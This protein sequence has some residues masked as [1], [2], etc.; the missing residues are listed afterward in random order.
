VAEG[1]HAACGLGADPVIIRQREDIGALAVVGAE[2]LHLSFLDAVYRRHGGD[3]LCTNR[4]SV[5]SGDLPAEHALAEDVERAL[6]LLIADLA[7][8]WILTC[9]AIGGH[10][11]HRI[12]RTA[13]L[14]AAGWQKTV[15]WEDVPY[16]FDL[17]P[18]RKTASPLPAPYLDHLQLEHMRAKLEAVGR[19]S[20]QVRMLWSGQDWK[21]LLLDQAAVRG[22][23]GGFEALWASGAEETS[24]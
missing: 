11:D 21:Q 22:T 12:T 19:Y 2:P 8:A 10:V 18:S 7:P 16:A 9:A 14:R 5:L 1:F 23:A 3:W 17:P 6:H 13:T 15:L 4:D 20:T 24:P